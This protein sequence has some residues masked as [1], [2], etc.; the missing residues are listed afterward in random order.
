MTRF[1]SNVLLVDAAEAHD[2]QVDEAVTGVDRQEANLKRGKVTYAV[3][4][5]IS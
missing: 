1:L 4:L 5:V 3:S 2:R